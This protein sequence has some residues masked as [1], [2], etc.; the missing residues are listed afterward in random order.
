MI[1]D[2]ISSADLVRAPGKLF[3]AGE[4]AVLGGA[5]ALVCAVEPW[6]VAWGS[7]DRIQ[8]IYPGAPAV[9]DPSGWIDTSGFFAGGEKSG[10]GSSAAAAVLIAAL[11]NPDERRPDRLFQPA[12]EVH[13]EIKG[14]GGS[15][16]DI[17]A[18]L[19]GGC[20]LFARDGDDW[21]W[22]PV[23]F[24]ADGWIGIIQAGHS[25]DTSDWIRKFKALS[26]SS[27]LD[28]WQADTESIVHGFRTI[29]DK[30]W[31]QQ[32]QRACDLYFELTR[33]LSPDIFPE[34]FMACRNIGESLGIGFKPSGAGGGDV[35]IFVGRGADRQRD[36]L[37]ELRKAG[38]AA[39]ISVPT[40]HGLHWQCA[41]EQ[42]AK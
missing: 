25:A 11:A 29:A 24:P 32:F 18:I 26:G 22:E 42:G 3:L 39:R 33:L 37:A 34:S 2:M 16:G 7:A 21:T 40:Q 23:G 12:M 13:T 8:G 15:G 41:A 38:M 9:A 27:D 19:H 1:P 14:S 10:V 35:G 28:N 5:P 6:A 20:G 30:D 31:S 4:Y 36:L 17:A